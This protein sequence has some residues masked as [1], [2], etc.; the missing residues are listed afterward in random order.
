MRGTATTSTR[1]VPAQRRRTGAPPSPRRRPVS[2]ATVGATARALDTVPERPARRPLRAVPP[3]DVRPPRAP[4]VLFVLAI[5]AAGL[6]AMLLLNT[7]V[8]ENAFRLHALDQHQRKL[9]LTEERLQREV[10]RKE[11]PDAVAR[12][13]RRLGLVPAGTPAFIR[14]PDGKVLGVPVPAKAPAKPVNNK[15]ANTKPA[16]NKPT[17]QPTGKPSTRAAG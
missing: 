10:A 7:A 17:G 9:D 11:S 8:N 2:E 13:A 3:S 15:P 5:A 4:F 16:N 6:V 12:S 14:L 1:G